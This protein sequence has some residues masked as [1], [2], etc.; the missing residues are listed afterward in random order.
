M[1]LQWGSTVYVPRM[2]KDPWRF[3]RNEM[4]LRP[5]SPT[6]THTRNTDRACL[7]AGRVRAEQAGPRGKVAPPVGPLP[8]GSGALAHGAS[9]HESACLRQAWRQP[10][11]RDHSEGPSGESAGSLS[12]TGN[13]GIVIVTISTVKTTSFSVCHAPTIPQHYGESVR[14]H[15]TSTFSKTNASP[16]ARDRRLAFPSGSSVGK[17]LLGLRRDLCRLWYCLVIRQ[18]IRLA[19]AGGR[20]MVEHSLEWIPGWKGWCSGSPC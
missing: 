10:C 2:G 12:Q 9:L 15:S 20:V 1:F 13:K 6:L 7:P 16:G 5:A 3:V 18:K 14:S 4:S 11:A 17:N 19:F 8:P